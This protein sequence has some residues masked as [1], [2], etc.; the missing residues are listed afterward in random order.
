MACKYC[1][2]E[3]MAY[4]H[5]KDKSGRDLYQRVAEEIPYD[6]GDIGDAEPMISWCIEPSVIDWADHL[7]RLCIAAYDRDGDECE[8]SIPIRHCPMCGRRLP[9]SL[10]T[11]TEGGK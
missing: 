2:H 6:D 4:S 5:H 8:L 7:P 1:E 9:T 10:E 3:S 11:R